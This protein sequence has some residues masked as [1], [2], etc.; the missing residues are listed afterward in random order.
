MMKQTLKKNKG[1]FSCLLLCAYY[2]YIIT[3]NYQMKEYKRASIQRAPVAIYNIYSRFLM[4]L[5]MRSL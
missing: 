2:M 3:G 1:N 4:I 5:I